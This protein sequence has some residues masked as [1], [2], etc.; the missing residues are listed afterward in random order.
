MRRRALIIVAVGLLFPLGASADLDGPP[1]FVLSYGAYGSGDGKFV[2]PYGAAVD[3]SGRVYVADFYG[4]QVQVF[5]EDGS[6]LGK[7]G[8]YG[9]GA[10]QFRYPWRITVDGSDD[11]YVTE[12]VGNRVQ[13][14]DTSGKYLAVFGSGQL[15][16]PCDVAV[17]GSGN[18]FVISQADH[19]IMKFDAKGSLVTKWGSRGSSTGRFEYPYSVAVDGNGDVY[20]ADWG[21]DRVQ[22]FDGKGTFLRTWGSYGLIGSS[23]GNL[24]GKFAEPA[25]IAVNDDGYVFVADRRNDRVQVFDTSGNFVMKWGTRGS[26]D[27]QFNNPWDVTVDARDH[28]YVVDRY[29]SRVQEFEL[30]EPNQPP[31]AAVDGGGSFELG[32]S[33]T[34]TADVADA[35]GDALDYE[36]RLGSVTVASGTI[37]SGT[38]KSQEDPPYLSVDSSSLGLGT[39]VFEFVVTDGN[40]DPVSAYAEV[41]IV[42]T[43]APKIGATGLPESLWPANHKMCEIPFDL[44]VTDLGDTDPQIEIEI[45]SSE[46]DDAD[47]DGDG[48]TTQDIVLSFA[49]DILTSSPD[50]AFVS[51]E[52]PYSDWRDEFESM[53][54]RAER[55]GKGAGRTYTVTVTATDASGNSAVATWEIEVPHDKGKGK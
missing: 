54:L 11:I 34:L 4:H 23:S 43:T 48:S 8:K 27:G 28:V 22:V 39:Y 16:Q 14:F 50:A 26:G 13:K 10:G 32:Q 47:G 42:D 33:V 30:S 1:D 12:Y 21:N 52:G 7:W 2:M 6:F 41:V 15:R 51:W 25:G 18:L 29:N 37:S 53:E 24:D 20:V 40:S 38:S 5:D 49:S 17:D 31:T 3:S 19:Q 45:A 9:S 55:A 44:A 35:D 36:W 46:P